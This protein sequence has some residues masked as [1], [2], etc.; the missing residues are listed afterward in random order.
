MCEPCG[1]PLSLHCNLFLS[2]LLFICFSKINKFV[3]IFQKYFESVGECDIEPELRPEVLEQN[4][5]RLMMA[6]QERER[7]IQEEIRRL[8][9]LQRLAEKVHR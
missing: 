1:T 5:G 8:E 9:K 7:D 4:W 2:N 6:H 3:F